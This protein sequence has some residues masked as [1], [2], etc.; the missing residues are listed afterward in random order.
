VGRR[1]AL[2]AT[3]ALLLA[4]PA[5]ASAG[6]YP[7]P[8]SRACA[9]VL[10][11]GLHRIFPRASGIVC[12]RAR[13]ISA[14]WYRARRCWDFGAP[15][16]ARNTCHLGAWRCEARPDPADVGNLEIQSLW[17]RCKRGGATVTIA[18]FPEQD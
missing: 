4:L 10:L 13:T 1:A 5:R 6:P 15:A 9:K 3:L 8:G 16:P 12:G 14:Y 2:I 17:A 18:T 11:G 7:N